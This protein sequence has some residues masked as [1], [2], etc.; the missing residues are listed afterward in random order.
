[1]LHMFDTHIDW[2]YTKTGTRGLLLHDT[3]QQVVV[4]SVVTRNASAMVPQKRVKGGL[5]IF[6]Q[7]VAQLSLC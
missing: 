4:H 2:R 5:R 3:P 1:M 7:N 6:H